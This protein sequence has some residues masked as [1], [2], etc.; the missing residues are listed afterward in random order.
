[1]RGANP[2]AQLHMVRSKQRIK[3]R[4]PQQHNYEKRE[5]TSSKE[6][7]EFAAAMCAIKSGVVKFSTVSENRCVFVCAWPIR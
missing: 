7:N 5:F 3:F 1:M 2:I 6:R 4:A